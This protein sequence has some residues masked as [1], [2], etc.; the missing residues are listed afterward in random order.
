MNHPNGTV[1]DLV[2]S[3]DGYRL[4][5]TLHLPT[6]NHPPILFGSHGLLGTRNSPKQQG[7]ADLCMNHNWAFFRFD[8]RGCGD[9][10]GD[11]SDVADF[12]GRCIDLK[13]AIKFILNQHDFNDRVGLFGSSLGGSVCLKV[14]VDVSVQAI[15]TCAAPLCTA[16]LRQHDDRAHVP[17]VPPAIRR[18]PA[19]YFDLTKHLS[20]IR[21]IMILH[22]DADTVVPVSH[23]RDIYE[24]VG[25][26]KKLIIQKQGDHPMS[27]PF[28]QQCFY[29]EAGKWLQRCLMSDGFCF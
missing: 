24:R 26:P 10:E 3:S 8:H 22:G 4:T 25:T 12:S 13:H 1:Q 18:N 9:S 27:Q 14:A 29:A 17:G 11:E 6:V 7:M 21:H 23:A 5:G 19:F 20:N 2:F 16:P 15:I 28:H